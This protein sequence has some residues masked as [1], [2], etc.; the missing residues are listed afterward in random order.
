MPWAHAV[1]FAPDGETLVTTSGRDVRLWDVA[2]GKERSHYPG[3]D[4]NEALAISPDGKTLAFASVPKSVT[5]WEPATGKVDGTRDVTLVPFL[6]LADIEEDGRIGVVVAIARVLGV[7][8][9]DLLSGLLEKVAVR[10]HR[11]PIYSDLPRAIV[12]A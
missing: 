1:V 10:A 5:L 8:L 9:V 3:A 6:A 2:T 12:V 11:F 4:G 7:D